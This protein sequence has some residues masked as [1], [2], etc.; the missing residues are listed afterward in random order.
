[1]SYTYLQERGGAYSAEC[2]S[3]IDP[4]ALS[5]LTSIAERHFS[6]GSSMES[7]LGSPCG[8]MSQPS[9]EHRGEESQTSCAVDSLART[10]VQQEKARGSA[11][12]EAGCGQKWRESS[13]RW[14][15]ASSSW[16]THR[17]LWEEDLP[18]SS[19]TLPEWGMMLD[20]ECWER[21]T[22]VPPIIGNDSGYLPT[23]RASVATHGVCWKRAEAGDHRSQ[24]EDFL[25]WLS[26]NNGGRRVSGRTV[27]PDF[28]DWLMVWPIGWS[29]CEPLAMAKFQQWLQWHGLPS[30]E[31]RQ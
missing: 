12:R 23:L 17:C 20:G 31:A 29:D 18:W 26:L 13:A 15:R 6:S 14:D 5:K 28:A 22:S 21:L 10:S 25:A 9:T 4:F 11:E 8:M 30:Q 1:M 2:F 19:V 7:C 16:K 27:N 24:I 3:D